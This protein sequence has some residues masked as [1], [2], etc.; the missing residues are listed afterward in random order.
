MSGFYKNIV[1]WLSIDSEQGV[2]AIEYGLIAS[3][4]AIAIIVAVTLVGTNLAGLFTYVAG[5]VVAP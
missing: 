5:K 1:S 3:L 4:I 2:T